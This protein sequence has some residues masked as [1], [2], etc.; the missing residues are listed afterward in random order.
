MFARRRRSLRA[1]V[2]RAGAEARTDR[3]AGKGPRSP[4]R[5]YR[6][7]G[8]GGSRGEIARRP[9]RARFQVAQ[10]IRSLRMILRPS[11]GFVF[12]HPAHFIALRFGTWLAPIAPGTAGTLLA[13]P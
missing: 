5:P 13:F 1:G 6:C 3:G 4:A 2:H 11:R 9:V 12:A 8:T 7:R 10:G